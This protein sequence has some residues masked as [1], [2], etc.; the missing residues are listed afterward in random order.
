MRDLPERM[1]D[2]RYLDIDEYFCST[3]ESSESSPI[4][5][6]PELQHLVS[7]SSVNARLWRT[8]NPKKERFQETDAYWLLFSALTN[9]YENHYETLAPSTI[10]TKQ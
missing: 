1:I 4:V 7:L 3:E 5:N 6:L 8:L 9:Y 2:E 10:A